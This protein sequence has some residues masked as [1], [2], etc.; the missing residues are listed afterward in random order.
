MRC[1][2]ITYISF[3]N[4]CIA[5]PSNWADGLNCGYLESQHSWLNLAS[6]FISIYLLE[7]SHQNFLIIQTPLF[8]TKNFQVMFF[9]MSFCRIVRTSKHVCDVS[10]C[11]CLWTERPFLLSL[12]S[13]VLLR[14]SSC[15]C[16][17]STRSETSALCCPHR[18][19]CWSSWFMTLSVP[20]PQT[21]SLGVLGPP[22]VIAA[23]RILE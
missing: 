14:L 7:T 15:P 16:G 23:V 21:F 22:A 13:S 8:C 18:W 2:K 19:A 4:S 10:S 5:A 9:S 20:S 6:L 3:P 17:F 11:R 12:T 1:S